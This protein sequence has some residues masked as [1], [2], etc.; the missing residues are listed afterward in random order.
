MTITY[1]QLIT[2]IIDDGIVAAKADYTNADETHKLEGSIAGFEACRN[3]NPR[4]LVVLWQDAERKSMEQYRE[5]ADITKYWWWRCYAMEVEWVCNVVS[6]GLDQP[7]MAH[8]PTT[9]GAMKYA[10]IVGVASAV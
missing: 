8:L 5:T 1:A 6:V 9:R 7:L 10:E 4:E 2:R 3:K